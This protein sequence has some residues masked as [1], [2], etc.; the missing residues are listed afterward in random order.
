MGRVHLVKGE[1]TTLEVQYRSPDDRKPVAKLI[2]SVVNDAPS[3]EAV[4]AARK[5]DL[6]IAA[7]G[8][9]SRLEGEEMPVV[10]PDFSAA[11]AR[12]SISLSPRRRWWSRLRRRAN[13]W[14]SCS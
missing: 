9:T 5:A 12:A 3:A 11:T 2:W 14:S 13:R 10:S 1:K 7:V 4:A 8:I 6:V